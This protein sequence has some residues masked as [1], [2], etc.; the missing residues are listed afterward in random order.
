MGRSRD[1]PHTLK[2]HSHECSPCVFA[3]HQPAPSGPTS[4][5]LVHHR[6]RSTARNRCRCVSIHHL[7]IARRAAEP[8]VPP[9]RFHR[10][11]R[12]E[13]GETNRGSAGNLQPERHVSYRVGLHIDGMRRLP[14]AGRLRR[15]FRPAKS[16]VARHT[17][18]RM[19]PLS[20]DPILKPD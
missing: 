10:N 5:A 19:V 20:L 1:R 9:R 12:V 18:W 11:R 3:S 4:R 6:G 16:D 15:T 13:A 17:A 8:L 2:L 7:P 14:A